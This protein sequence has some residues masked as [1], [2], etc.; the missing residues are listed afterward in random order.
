MSSLQLVIIMSNS[1][2]KIQ[3]IKRSA[4]RGASLQLVGALGQ[5]I[6]RIAASTILAR[7]LEPAD[8]GLFGM[9][10]LAR[11]LIEYLGNLGM[12]AGIIAKKKLE[13]I[14]LS[15]GFWMM[16][17]SRVILFFLAFSSAP[18]IGLFFNEPKLVGI[19]RAISFTFLFSIASFVPMWIF[20]KHLRFKPI[21][22]IRLLGIFIESTLAVT[23]V[24]MT[25]L[26]VYSLVVALLVSSIF[27]HITPMIWCGWFPKFQFSKN[28][29]KYLFRFGVN[30]LGA[31]IVTYLHEKLDYWI[32]GKMFGDRSLGLY[33]FA[34]RIPHIILVRVALPISSV[35]FPALSMVKDNNTTLISGYVKAIKYI[36]FLV[37]PLLGGLASLAPLIIHVLWGEKWSP[38]INPLRIL[39]LAAALGCLS[40]PISSIFYC[41]NRP[42][43]PFRLGVLHLLTAIVAIGSLGPIYGLSGVAC[44][45]V[46]SMLPGVFGI[47]IAFRIA[48]SHIALLLRALIAPL[49]C[50]IASSAGAYSIQYLLFNNLFSNVSCLIL[51][52]CCGIICYITSLLLLFKSQAHELISTVKTVI[53]K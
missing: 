49:C 14:D 45:M 35:V 38:I 26:G 53:G 7:T 21:V 37:F 23:L 43:M 20:Q 10:I 12:G 51:A 50:T 32:V 6:I 41:K 47:W 19:F 1:N 52:L 22:V 11:E 30:G 17:V 8:F 27:I 34:Y 4:G 5:T 33:E 25:S 48:N 9:A 46:I 3:D 39:C 2:T 28:S 18:L 13:D 29:F 24:L 16:A 42:E 36:A 44:G 31:S 40:K 15:T